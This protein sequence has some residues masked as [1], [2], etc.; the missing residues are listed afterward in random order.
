MKRKIPFWIALIAALSLCTA[1]FAVARLTAPTSYGG[2]FT[3][4]MKFST[5]NT[6]NDGGSDKYDRT[7]DHEE[8]P[9]FYSADIYNMEST[10][11]R[12][13]LPH[14]KTM[15]QTSWWSCG[16][17]SVLMVLEYYKMRGNL[18]EEYLAVLREDHSDMHIGTCLDQMIDMLETFDGLEL[19][20]TY[21]YIDRLDD[22]NMSF[23]RKQLEAGFPIIIGWNDW[24]GHW[25]VAIGYDTMGTESEGD[26]VLIIA[27]PFD[28][29]D[30]NQDGYGVLSAERFT[31]NFSFYT[32]F[33]ENHVTEKC[34]IVV[35]P[36]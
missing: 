19:V 7:M 9:Y 6:L 2:N 10:D 15:N 14:F 13:I 28:T 22:I 33:P 16:Q 35:K 5:A 26:D 11:T 25:E 23:L 20:T 1:S 36:K 4:E 12:F 8:S 29:S 17:A 21:D 31:S 27:D 32:F 24:G 18:D 34:F 3:Q 30:H